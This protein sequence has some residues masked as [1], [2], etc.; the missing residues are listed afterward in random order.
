MSA[1]TN[2]VVTP[3]VFLSGTFY[4]VTRL[5]EPFFTFTQ[6]NPIFYLIDGFRYGMIGQSDGSIALGA[7]IA[8]VLNVVMGAVCYRVFKSGYKLKA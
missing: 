6:W 2:F 3:L 1:I 5:P 8:V 7:T 4:S